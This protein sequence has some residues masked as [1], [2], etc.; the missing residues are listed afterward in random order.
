MCPKTIAILT[1]FFSSFNTQLALPVFQNAN[2]GVTLT[3]VQPK[4]PN[5]CNILSNGV[6]VHHYG[7]NPRELVSAFIF[8]FILALVWY[9]CLCHVCIYAE[10]EQHLIKGQQGLS[11]VSEAKYQVAKN[12]FKFIKQVRHHL[13]DNFFT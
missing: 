10:N 3:L 13:I 12:G 11:A 1:C 2:G 8:L 7:S 9:T 6:E 5:S 4:L